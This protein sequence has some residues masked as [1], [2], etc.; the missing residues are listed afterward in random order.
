PQAQAAPLPV[1]PPSE[2]PGPPPENCTPLQVTFS[3]PLNTEVVGSTVTR[4]FLALPSDIIFG[5][6]FSRVCAHMDISPTDALL[7]YKFSGDPVQAA[8]YHLT[9]EEELREAMKKAIEKMRRARTREVFVEIHNLQLQRRRAAGN[10]KRA[11]T[12]LENNPEPD[13]TVTFSHELRELKRHL[14][15]QRHHGQYCYVSPVDG[16]HRPCDVYQLT[17]WA[18]QILFENASY[19][20]PPHDMKFDHATKRQRH[21]EGCKK[22]S[23]QPE[24]HVHI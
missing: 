13:T 23:G 5:D 8:P 21:E 4:V 3:I 17:L 6:F 22:S 15:C 14:E 7:G 10:G 16:R 19:Q 2:S 12:A 11:A 1:Y 24:I 18:K 20:S 9:N